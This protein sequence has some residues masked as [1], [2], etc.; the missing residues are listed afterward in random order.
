[1][2][3]TS[4]T[5][6]TCIAWMA[7]T[8]CR[9][10]NLSDAGAGAAPTQQSLQ[11]DDAPVKI[12]S[13]YAPSGYVKVWEDQFNTATIDAS[14]W[15]AA[16]LRDPV[17]GDLVPG[18]AGDHL[19]NT[20]YAGYITPEDTYIENGSLVLRNQKRSYSGS[21]PAGSFNYTSGW[22]MSMHRGF[23]NKG[24]IEIK[25]KFPS[26]DK[27][28]PAAWLIA[29][30]LTWGPEWDMFEYFGYRSDVG[31]DNMGMHLAYGEWPD[32]SWSSAWIKPFD[33]TYDCEAWHVYGFEW[34]DTFAAW[35]IDGV[36]VR[37]LNKGNAKGSKIYKKW[38]NENMYI[39]LNNGQRSS[40]P[41]A[42]TTWP[43][44]LTVDYIEVYQK[45]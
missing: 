16:S 10:E 39:V 28:W 33:G 44:Y 9:R 37:K 26:G 7:I 5:M 38:P 12:A 25:A 24:Y 31:Y 21:S 4:L 8:G 42:T 36:Q 2:K 23:F 11:R 40:S 32:V 41:D 35:Y 22:V 30:D 19:L 3:V 13:L 27:V 17:S 14:K 6:L 1:M 34:T 45:P 20:E 18:A 43:N 15:V 29:E